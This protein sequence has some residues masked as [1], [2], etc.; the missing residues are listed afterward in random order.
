MLARRRKRLLILAAS[1]I[2]LLGVMSAMLLCGFRTSKRYYVCG[3]C[4]ARRTERTFCYVPLPSV[5]S[6]SKYTDYYLSHV[7]T[8]HRHEWSDAGLKTYTWFRLYMVADAFP[9][10]QRAFA[11]AARGYGAGNP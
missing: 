4:R 10:G 8:S 6:R 9:G 11:I 7:D 5:V 3:I 2:L 1:V